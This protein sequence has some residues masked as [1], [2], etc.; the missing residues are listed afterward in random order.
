MNFLLKIFITLINA[1]AAIRGILKKKTA[2]QN[3]AVFTGEFF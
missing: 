2:L 1:K 3:F